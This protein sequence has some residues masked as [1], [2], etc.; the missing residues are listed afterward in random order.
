MIYCMYLYEVYD[1]VR[2]R[3]KL[4]E[5]NLRDYDKYHLF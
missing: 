2:S 5:K 1:Y 3:P 4:P